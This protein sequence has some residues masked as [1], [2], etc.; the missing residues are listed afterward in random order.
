MH[1]F[2]DFEASSLAKAGY[3]IEIA[4]V[5]EDGTAETHLLR[6]LPAWTDWDPRAEAVH[7]ISREQL[8]T[9]G[10]PVD[11]IVH[12]M[13]ERL[14][15]HALYASSPSWDGKWLS[16]LLR[17]GGQPRHALRLRDT[18]EA[19]H[20]AAI[21]PLARF[22]AGPALEA[23]VN[24]LIAQIRGADEGRAIAHRALPDALHEQQ[25]WLAI[26]TEAESLARA[27]VRP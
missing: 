9:E 17:A 2:L 7:H 23:A 24:A 11:A 22:L 14:A 26:R 6:P 15:G 20:E 25:L 18:D 19:Q 27:A 3:P 21:E 13:L 16:L 4:W 12:L 1:V 8:L 10:E 5:F